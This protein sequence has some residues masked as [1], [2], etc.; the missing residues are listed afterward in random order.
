MVNSE[1]DTIFK[2]DPVVR[3]LTEEDA[4]PLKMVVATLFAIAIAMMT[5]QPYAVANQLTVAQWQ[6]ILQLTPTPGLGCYAASYPST[7]WNPQSCGSQPSTQGEDFIVGNCGLGC[8]WNAQASNNPISTSKG[9]FSSETGYQSEYDT[10]KGDGWFSLQ[11]NTNT[12]PFTIGGHPTTAWEQFIL[13]SQG[14]PYYLYSYLLIQYTLV[15]YYTQ[16]TNCPSG[17][18]RDQNNNCFQWTS[19]YSIPYKSPGLLSG[20]TFSGSAKSTGDTATFCQLDNCWA[21]SGGDTLSLANSNWYDSEFNVFGYLA[22]A[23]FNSGLSLN[24]STN[25]YIGSG[26]NKRSYTGEWNN[27]NLG[28]SCTSGGNYITFSESD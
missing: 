7:V 2:S 18:N 14:T 19:W 12:Y 25:N 11:L 3:E 4:R 17:W 20:Y 9:A 23:I 28:A 22:G 10:I 27:L 24:L 5:T 21:N 15:G 26:C 13:A 6:E 16:Y 1:K 8:D